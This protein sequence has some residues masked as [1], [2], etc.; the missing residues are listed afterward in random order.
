MAS[1]GGWGT[2]W[3]RI[4]QGRSTIYGSDGRNRV[5]TKKQAGSRWRL[6][7]KEDVPKVDWTSD[8]EGLLL[9]ARIA[10]ILVAELR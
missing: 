5:Y 9:I 10:E 2:S 6:P 7:A 3:W 1:R 8:N 4:K